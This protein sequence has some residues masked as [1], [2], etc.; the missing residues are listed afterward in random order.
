MA[1]AVATRRASGKRVSRKFR[2]TSGFVRTF[3]EAGGG[4]VQ[5]FL[6]KRSGAVWQKR[7]FVLHDKYLTYLKKEPQ[8]AKDF[9]KLSLGS[10][11]LWNVEEVLVDGCD[12]T[13]NLGKEASRSRSGDLGTSRR[14][15]S[16]ANPS[17]RQLFGD[18]ATSGVLS[19]VASAFTSSKMVLRAEDADTAQRWVQAMFAGAFEGQAQ[20]AFDAQGSV[21]T[22]LVPGGAQADMAGVD[23]AD[24]TT[25]RDVDLAVHD[26]RV[27]DGDGAVLFSTSRLFGTRI[28][29]GRIPVETSRIEVSLSRGGT[30]V[31]AIRSGKLKAYLHG[32][33]MTIPLVDE[34]LSH[35]AIKV[36][37]VQNGVHAIQHDLEENYLLPVQS[38][39]SALL[40]VLV[41]GLGPLTGLLAWLSAVSLA[42]AALYFWYREVAM[43]SSVSVIPLHEGRELLGQSSSRRDQRRSA[44]RRSVRVMS[45]E[46]GFEAQVEEEV[47]HT[48]I[49]NSAELTKTEL[50]LVKELRA[51]V[52]DL[53][54]ETEQAGD[55]LEVYRKHID[56]DFRLVRFLR[57][58]NLN[59]K[60]AEKFLRASLKW[61]VD[62]GADDFVSRHMPP[63]GIV[64]YVGS[65]EIIDILDADGDR[66]PWYFRDKEGHLGVFVRNGVINVRKMYRKLGGTGPDLFREGVWLFQMLRDDLDRHHL[67]TNGAVATQVTLVIDLAGFSMSHQIPVNQALPLARKF[68]PKLLDG[69]PEILGSVTVINAPWLFN[70]VWSIIKP[71]L[72]ER[73]L[74]KISINGSNSR[75]YLK[76]IRARFDD[77]QIP[78]ALGGSLG[79][80]EDPYLSSRIPPQGPFFPD[81]GEALLKRG[82]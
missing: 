29:L 65:P 47:V 24:T 38:I 82:E 33:M 13:I 49:G 44:E 37:L 39:M 25:R 34:G 57:A 12:I 80:P 20:R 26:L 72:P 74:S 76:K 23:M 30:E 40:V 58:R 15:N 35:D 70:S 54:D 46:D 67:N 18:G 21:V 11:N 19:R 52:S 42:G 7:W 50:K 63:R 79:T 51:R 36:V 60:K 73:L 55:A 78:L 61:R 8:N 45:E 77:D 66:L 71:F 16:R 62:F 75:S 81:K 2:R 69:F 4:D 17:M 32:S 59:L 5:G 14:R 9:E 68:I 41:R 6:K 56:H 28:S 64:E 43:L 3:E 53:V 10:V 27:V 48:D 1:E 22:Q 31:G